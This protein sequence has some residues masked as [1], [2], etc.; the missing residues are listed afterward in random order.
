MSRRPANVTQA[1][2]ACALRAARQ[3]GPNWLVE[4]DGK[5]IR[6]V[7]G[8]PPAANDSKPPQPSESTL[9]PEEKWRL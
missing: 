2:L 8:L 6:M 4:L 3:A 7:Q 5:V 1:D 9:A